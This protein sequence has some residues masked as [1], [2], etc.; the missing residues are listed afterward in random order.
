MRIVDKY[1]GSWNRLRAFVLSL[2][3]FGVIYALE[4]HHGSDHSGSS[5]FALGFGLC[6][7]LIV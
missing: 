2:T 3:I 5:G 4:A 6:W 1:F 7:I